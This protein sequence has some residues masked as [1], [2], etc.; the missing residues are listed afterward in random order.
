MLISAYLEQIQDTLEAK[1]FNKLF[2]VEYGKT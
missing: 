1:I 2:N